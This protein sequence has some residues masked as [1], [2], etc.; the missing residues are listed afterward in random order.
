MHACVSV[1]G[2]VT[3]GCMLLRYP[4]QAA[5]QP[6]YGVR[7]PSAVKRPGVRSESTERESL[8]RAARD[9]ANGLLREDTLASAEKI[10][11]RWWRPEP[12]P[13]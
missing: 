12:V 5:A 10:A 11:D 8:M 2:H 7:N 3:T 6:Q 1:P 9:D 4:L 13:C